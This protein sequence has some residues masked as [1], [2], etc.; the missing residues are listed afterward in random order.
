MAMLNHPYCWGDCHVN[1]VFVTSFTHECINF[2]Y[3]HTINLLQYGNRTGSCDTNL[4]PALARIMHDLLKFVSIPDLLF[5]LSLPEHFRSDSPSGSSYSALALFLRVVM[6]SWVRSGWP[7]LP[8]SPASSVLRMC[9]YW[10]TSCDGVGAENCRLMCIIS[11]WLS[12]A[13]C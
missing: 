9:F 12:G 11:K 5:I 13:Q 8:I 7:G 1:V 3:T 2:M 6:N 4:F 10:R